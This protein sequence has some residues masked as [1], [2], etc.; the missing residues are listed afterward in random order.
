MSDYQDPD[1]DLN[2]N[3][4]MDESKASKAYGLLASIE[5]V[6]TKISQLPVID[7]DQKM[8]APK[9]TSSS[10]QKFGIFSADL[11]TTLRGV[12]REQDSV[13]KLSYSW[14]SLYN[15]E[16]RLL[17]N[18]EKQEKTLN[19][20]ASSVS[21]KM[22]TV[23]ASSTGKYHPLFAQNE[24]GLIRHSK[25][26]AQAAYGLAGMFNVPGDKDRFVI[27]GLMHDMW[28]LGPEGK[29]GFTDPK[30]GSLAAE[31]L[32]KIGLSDAAGLA[33]PHMGNFSKGQYK[34]AQKI[35]T[36]DQRLLNN[37]DWLMSRTYAQDYVNWDDKGNIQDMNLKGLWDESLKR[38]DAKLDKKS[39]LLIP[40]VEEQ[41]KAA[42]QAKKMENSWHSTA[43][44]AGMLL[45]IL[46]TIAG[47]GLSALYIGMK[48]TTAGSKQINDGLGMFTGTS[49]A[50][51]L[52]NA[53]R[54]AKSGI[55]AGSI[56]K[57]VAGLAAKRGQFK[58][59]GAGDLLPM[60]MAGTIEGLMISDKPMQEVYGQIID[61]FTKQ[62]L[63]TKDQAQKDKLLALVGS[64]L[65]PEAA[66]LVNM[67]ASLG[68]NWAGL[69]ARTSPAEGFLDWSDKVREVNAD[70][71]T[72]LN[73]IKDTWKGL[74]VEFTALFGN[75]FLKFIDT[76]FRQLGSGLSVYLY[77][78]NAERLG[79]DLMSSLS[80]AERKKLYAADKFGMYDKMRDE[81]KENYAVSEEGQKYRNMKK[82][83]YALEAA[84]PWHVQQVREN[85]NKR[86]NLGVKKIAGQYRGG[87]LLDAIGKL[88]STGEEKAATDSVGGDLNNGILGILGIT[89]SAENTAKR[90][91]LFQ[92]K[93]SK[94]F[95]K[96]AGIMDQFPMLKDTS[97]L[98]NPFDTQMVNIFNGLESG[99]FTE[100]QVL[101]V[102]ENYL[103]SV[104]T[105]KDED[106][107]SM[108]NGTQVNMNFSLPNGSDPTAIKMGILDAARE[109]P[110][111]IDN[112]YQAMYA[113]GYG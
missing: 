34:N 88:Y 19:L 83:L 71:Q 50:D 97:R 2:I 57:A 62:L 98:S 40:V 87:D 13:K 93:Y 77:N 9:V 90:W 81:A 80:P 1:L 82:E 48:E 53:L 15:Q 54:E 24:G 65:G 109:I 73:G 17:Q 76:V 111:I 39:G 94:K 103:K 31:A 78:K 8:K 74:F 67:Q 59:T 3:L 55:A 72:S 52:D 7:F 108:N 6:W 102:L 85:F 96:A 10:T 43:A 45:G 110:S 101:P 35:S 79:S 41:E 58:L 64:N 86:Y 49:N 23:P 38:G 63:G 11:E 5:Q 68:T 28:K 56:N 99:V 18:K 16:I 113:G 46:K 89:S 106:K 105:L 95:P 104:D 51:I 33:G 42:A 26:V 61:M 66:N 100:E 112:A 84:D 92:N 47:L 32:G 30:H 4:N 36:F 91:S 29:F 70:M 12:A 22:K 107:M 60:A 27:A 75:P 44:S 69:G 37:A 25:A 14:D 20:L 21:E